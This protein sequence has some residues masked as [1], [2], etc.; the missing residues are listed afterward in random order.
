MTFSRANPS[1]RYEALARQYRQMHVEGERFLGI[2]AQNTFPGQ[3]LPAQ[4]DRIKQLIVAT[5]AQNVL[6]YGCGKGL[7]YDLRGIRGPDGRSHESI[8][9][10]WDVDYIQC[11]D[12][13]YEPFSRLPAGRFEGVIC[14]DVLEHCPEEDLDW[15][16]GELFAY[17]QRFVFA[18]I[19]CYPARKRLP[20]GENAHTTIRPPDWWRALFERTA[21]AHPGLVWQA[22]IEQLQDTTTGTKKV[23]DCIG[24]AATGPS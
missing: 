16:V 4:A 22:W 9:D 10:Y 17:A 13:C 20:S 14:T 15:I 11:Y 19:A 24:S 1:P 23:E 2:P 6:D 5:G 8:Q 18:S 3:S 7:Q 21:A 12:P